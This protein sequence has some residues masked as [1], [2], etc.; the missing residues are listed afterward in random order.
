MRLGVRS[1]YSVEFCSGQS[2]TFKQQAKLHTPFAL[3]M[4]RRALED[5]AFYQDTMSTW[6][7][8]NNADLFYDPGKIQ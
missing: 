6:Y 7:F 3:E 8:R 1:L 2:V 5:V 4:L